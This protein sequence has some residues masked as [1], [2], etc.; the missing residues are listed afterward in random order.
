MAEERTIGV[1]TDRANQ[2]GKLHETFLRIYET[3]SRRAARFLWTG[4]SWRFAASKEDRGIRHLGP[5]S[6]Q[7]KVPTDCF[8][9]PCSGPC[10]FHLDHAT[11]LSSPR[12]MDTHCPRSPGL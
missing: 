1:G 12:C 2:S 3:K 11:C 4:W 7:T 9:W 8:S 6:N 10:Y 5:F